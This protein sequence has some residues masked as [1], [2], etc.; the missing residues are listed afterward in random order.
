MC[1]PSRAALMTARHAV[2]SGM[3][4]D[5][6]DFYVMGLGPG[7]LPDY[8][9]T[10]P[11]ALR[12]C[13]FDEMA[14]ALRESFLGDPACASDRL[15]AACLAKLA[16]TFETYDRHGENIKKAEARLK[17]L[18]GA[19]KK[20]GRGWPLHGGQA[21][22]GAR[23]SV[24]VLDAV[25]AA[26]VPKKTC[27][28]LVAQALDTLD[29]AAIKFETHGFQRIMHGLFRKG[30]S[31]GS[32]RDIAMVCPH[33][34]GSTCENAISDLDSDYFA[35]GLRVFP[36]RDCDVSLISSSCA[37]KRFAAGLL[38][39][40]QHYP[41]SRVVAADALSYDFSRHCAQ[42]G[43]PGHMAQECPLGVPASSAL[44]RAT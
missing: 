9:I 25:L 33:V 2:R 14:P 10:L 19:L 28:W 38:M 29:A 12:E 21:L 18:V 34:L 6:P 17:A 35:F 5:N 32:Y 42:C 39:L 44:S 23:W 27:A 3:T 31:E 8:G 37:D 24:R 30:V 16:E 26:D 1:T 22:V 40:L 15:V 43:D 4:S 7:G 11:E 36:P 41:A 20:T 13:H